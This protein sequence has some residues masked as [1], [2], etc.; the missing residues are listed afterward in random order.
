[1]DSDYNHEFEIFRE[2]LDFRLKNHFTFLMNITPKEI[3]GRNGLSFKCMEESKR[4]NNPQMSLHI[5]YEVKKISFIQFL[6][7]S[8]KTF[9][10]TIDI[11]KS[12][13][14]II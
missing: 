14:Y 11:C 6:Q 5:S 10:K 9:E 2:E 7:I 4:I 13:W 8:Q 3:H 1:M 12:I